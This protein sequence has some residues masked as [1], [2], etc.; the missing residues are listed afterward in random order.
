MFVVILAG[1][2]GTRLWPMSRRARPKQLQPLYSERSLLQDTYDR[3]RRV[4]SPD[5]ILVSTT[6]D[7]AEPCREQLPELP[8]DQVLIEPVGRNTGPAVGY[9]AAWCEWRQPG[10]VVATVHS[11]H[12]VTRPETF[13]EALRLAER[14]VR[15]RPDH[16]LTIGVEPT[17]GHPGFGYIHAPGRPADGTLA[18]VPVRQFVEKPSPAVAQAWFECGEYL[19]NA[20]YFVFTAATMLDRIEAY[21]PQVAAGLERIRAALGTAGAREVLEREYSRLEAAPIDRMVFEPESRAGRVLTIPARLGWD[22]LGSWATVRDLLIEREGG[23]V[24][25]RGEVIAIDSHADLIFAAAGRLVAVVGIDDVI[26]VDT[27]DALLICRADRAQEVGR[28]LAQLPADDPR[29]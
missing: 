2:Y 16:L 29:R 10:A 17:W 28:V 20:G 7:L 19:W 8:P 3:V 21:A 23:G 9:A 5:R 13:A 24:A 4:A 18:V 25:T 15:D 14:T 22:D 11:D 1:G 27:P 26:V 12:V 6:A